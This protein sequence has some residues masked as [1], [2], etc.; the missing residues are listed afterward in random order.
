M[1][2]AR[3]CAF[4]LSQK[5]C[6]VPGLF[7]NT[8][9]LIGCNRTKVKKADRFRSGW[10]TDQK[11]RLENENW[12]IAEIEEQNAEVITTSRTSPNKE[13]VLLSKIWCLCLW[14]SF[15]CRKWKCSRESCSSGEK[16][17]LSFICVWGKEEVNTDCG[18][19]KLPSISTS[20]AT[21]T[22]AGCPEPLQLLWLM[23][24]E[25]AA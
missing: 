12:R 14:F 2:I 23:H 24:K 13:T 6:R 10:Q 1:I 22:G 11:Q 4:K 7:T 15:A 8:V 19:M 17:T 9:S 21:K 5:V 18:G 16:I 25:H 20:V 3:T